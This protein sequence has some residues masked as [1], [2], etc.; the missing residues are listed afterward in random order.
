MKKV[1]FLAIAAALVGCAK[2]EGPY[3]H[4]SPKWYYDHAEN[5]TTAELKWC[6]NQPGASKIQSCVDAA[7]AYQNYTTRKWLSTPPS[8]HP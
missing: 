1:I 4:Q 2:S 8:I 7:N 5:E 3:A 6:Q